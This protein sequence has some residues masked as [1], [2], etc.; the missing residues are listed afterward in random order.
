MERGDVSFT[1]LGRIQEIEWNIRDGRWQSALGLALTLPDIC[2]GIAYPEVVK[3]YRDGRAMLDRTG[4][5][6]RDVGGQYILWFDTFAAPFF[7]RAEA[8]EKPYICGERCWQLRCEY[9]HQNKGFI[10]DADGRDVQFHLGL[11]CGASVCQLDQPAGQEGVEHIRL[12][13]QQFCERL[14]LAA[15]SYYN[16][17]YSA[18]TFGLYRTPVI[19]FV[20]WNGAREQS[21]K[22]VAIIDPDP[23]MAAGTQRAL[24][25]ATTDVRVFLSPSQARSSLGRK[26]PAL[27][28]VAGQLLAQ[29]DQPWRSDRTTPVILLTTPYTSDGSEIQKEPGKLHRLRLPVAL[30]GLR[31]CV[32]EYL[33]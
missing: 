18:E 8:D 9:L 26:K 14:C 31:A 25:A 1:F 6:T 20:Q 23:V 30:E 24:S 10:N 12:D 3:K 27:W 32:Q 21:G 16:T 22:V 11:N 2:G 15:R 13:I 29:K 17:H 4:N 5:P 28:I 33:Q 19:D 7:K